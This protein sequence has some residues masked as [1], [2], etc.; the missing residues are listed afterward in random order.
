MSMALDPPTLTAERQRR[1]DDCV[2]MAY[3]IT[4]QRCGRFV[5]LDPFHDF[6][7]VALLALHKATIKF[8]AE[9]GLQAGCKFSTYAG[10]AIHNAL[11][12]ALKLF[13]RHGLARGMA[14]A[15]MTSLSEQQPLTAPDA[16]PLETSTWHAELRGVVGQLPRA[17]WRQVIEGRFFGGKT[18]T[19]LAAEL[20]CSKEWARQLEKKALAW[21]HQALADSE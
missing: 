2:K 21:L 17:E 9:Q 13:Y 10:T 19:Q 18:Y 6:Q 20:H 5:G 1:F 8:D 4:H 7:Q 12:Q 14:P 11:T 3:K 15:A 16:P